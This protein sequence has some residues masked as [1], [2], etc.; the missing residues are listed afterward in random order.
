MRL[1]LLLLFP[2]SNFGVVFWGGDFRFFVI[3]RGCD[4]I[5]TFFRTCTLYRKGSFVRETEGAHSLAR[6]DRP[7]YG[8]AL[9]EGEREMNMPYVI[10]YN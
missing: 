1:V 4:F 2:V 8:R 5:A 3:L 10:V 6:D 9:G 7:T